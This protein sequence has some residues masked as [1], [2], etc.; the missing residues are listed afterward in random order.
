MTDIGMSD[1]EVVYPKTLL[2]MLTATSINIIIVHILK[3][4]REVF[5]LYPLAGPVPVA[6]EA[7]LSPVDMV[8]CSK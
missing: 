7:L 2:N 1:L 4:T 3:Y 6:P 5:R 8:T